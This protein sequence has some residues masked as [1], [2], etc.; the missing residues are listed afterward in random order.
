MYMLSQLTKLASYTIVQ[1]EDLDADLMATYPGPSPALY[2]APK[3][4]CSIAKGEPTVG[5][6]RR[7][8]L[9][10]SSSTMMYTPMRNG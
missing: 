2:F 1:K 4:A 9:K 7:F 10:P 5:P 3:C 8:L 6:P